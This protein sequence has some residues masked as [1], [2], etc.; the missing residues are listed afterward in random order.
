MR[1]IYQVLGPKV[2]T[3]A[4]FVR[5]C[6]IVHRKTLCCERVQSAVMFHVEM[7]KVLLPYTVMSRIALIFFL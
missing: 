2:V 6:R 5:S 4:G 1:N 7:L 3:R